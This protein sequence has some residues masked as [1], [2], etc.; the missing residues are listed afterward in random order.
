MTCITLPASEAESAIAQLESETAGPLQPLGHYL[1]RLPSGPVS[2]TVATLAT[3]PSG[4][5][6]PLLQLL[7]Q[8]RDAVYEAAGG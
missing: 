4:L 6:E 1:R 5:P 3:L 2:D 8:L 7:T